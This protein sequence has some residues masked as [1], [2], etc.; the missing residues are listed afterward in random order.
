M[1]GKI[2]KDSINALD[3]VSPNQS[4]G[5][6]HGLH[7]ITAALFIV[8]DM[9]GGG[10]VTMPIA[11]LAAGSIGGTIGIAVIAVCFCY[12]AHLLGENWNTMCN[13]WPVY[14]EHCRK[15]YPEMA[16]RS[17]GKRARYLTSLVLNCMLYGVSMVY[18]SLS[19][20]IMNNIVAGIFDFNVGNC[21]MIVII[22]LLLLPVTLLKSPADFQ[23]AVVTAMVT[24][25]LSVALIFFGTALD[26]EVCSAARSIPEFNLG[27]LM[28]SFGTFMFGFG[29]HG[30]F[31]TIQHDMKQPT[32]FT[33]SSVLA[34]IIVLILYLP[35]TYLGYATYGDSLKNSI[36]NS[37]QD[38]VIQQF[39]NFFIA[40]HCILTLTIT[41]NPLNQEIEHKFKLPHGF[42][43]QRIMY[44]GGM[45]L[46]IVVSCL[47]FPEFEPIL[48]F[49]GGTAV[50]LTSAIMPC[51][52][53]LYLHA[54]GD[55]EAGKRED[56]D[57]EGYGLLEL[58]KRVVTRTSPTKLAINVFIIGR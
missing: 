19:A 18:L 27:S 4:Y 11:M 7:W 39:A 43:V 47:T 29:G 48:N 10:V 32:Q 21:K 3:G 36:I 16:Y 55:Y 12:T 5:K 2:T 34:F 38:N 56:S 49:I 53:N 31:P 28:L 50:A 54:T 20:K 9:A 58:S 45:M 6:P 46:A 22:A 15:P 8:A 41:I 17:M 40:I 26:H 57:D 44:R 25:T 23:W 51:L 24:T 37:I 1:T 30:V 35:I 52:F 13:R 33:R 42:G 14:R